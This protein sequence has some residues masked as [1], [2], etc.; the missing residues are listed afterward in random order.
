VGDPEADTVGLRVPDHRVALGVLRR[1]GPLA[2]TSA[3][4]SGDEPATDEVEAQTA[5]GGAVAVYLEGR[6]S[7]GPPSTVVDATDDPPR[8]LRAGAVEW[9]M[10]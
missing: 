2:V 1:F 6:G 5:L 8:V 7:G 3:N 10:S 4:R 9:A